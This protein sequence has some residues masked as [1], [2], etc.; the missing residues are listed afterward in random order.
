[1]FTY[2]QGTIG[3][4]FAKFFAGNLVHPVAFAVNVLC[5]ILEIHICIYRGGGV[6]AK[7]IV[8]PSIHRVFYVNFA[9]KKNIQTHGNWR[10][11]H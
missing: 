11:N 2:L 7:S 6:P 4:L 8:L 10:H 5:N 1:M 3:I 9:N